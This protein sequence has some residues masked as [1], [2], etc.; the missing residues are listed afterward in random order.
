[1]TQIVLNEKFIRHRMVD[2]DIDSLSELSRRAGL[3]RLTVHM[4]LRRGSCSL[5]TLAALAQALDCQPGDL[6]LAAP[7]GVAS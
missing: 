7:N 5:E 4:A 2:L 3:Y 6:L 1:M